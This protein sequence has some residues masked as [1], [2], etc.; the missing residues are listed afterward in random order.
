[1]ER[2]IKKIEE[3]LKWLWE[4]ECEIRC[5]RREIG[6]CIKKIRREIK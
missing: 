4:T 5:Y 3:R 1:M 2:E 6:E